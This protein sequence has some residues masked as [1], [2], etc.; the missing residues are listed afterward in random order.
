[1]IALRA[2]D[3]KKDFK[4]ICDT[5]ISGDSVIIARPKNENVV[6]LSE[7]KYNDM[8][9]LAK[10]ELSRQQAT[11]GNLITKSIKDLEDIE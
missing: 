6:L 2:I 7:K 3:L 8:Q 11:D 4:N 5:V 10:I 1:M 9:Y